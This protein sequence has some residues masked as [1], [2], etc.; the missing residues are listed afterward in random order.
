[1]EQS[2]NRM[3]KC[4]I[5]YCSDD[6]EFLNELVG[7]LNTVFDPSV[8]K[9]FY[10]SGNTETTHV[11]ESRSPALRK[12]LGDSD[13]MI[14]VLTDNYMR[15]IISIA[16]L[17]TFWYLD[18]PLIPI[19][20]DQIG[21]GFLKTLLGKD[22]I[23]LDLSK[24]AAEDISRS[25]TTIIHTLTTNGFRLLD[26]NRAIQNL[27]VLF[28]EAKQASP[29]RP[30]IGSGEKYSN[31]YQYCEKNGIMK[32]D[33][34]SML[35][36]T[37]VEHISD[38]KELFIVATTGS[39]LINAL[40]SEFLPAALSRGMT[41]TVL[42]PN[43]SSSFVS[44]VAE[45]EWPDNSHDHKDRFVR[46]FDS[47]IYN[48]KNCLARAKSLDPEHCGDIWLGC[49]YTLMR[50]TITLAVWDD[51]LWGR[52]SMTIPPMRTVDGTPSLIFSSPRDGT[53][54]GCLVYKHVLRVKEFADYKNTLF[55]LSE[56]ADI[57]EFSLENEGAEE[58]WR[59]LYETAKKNTGAQEGDAE[60]IEVAAQHPLRKDGK[61]GNEFA[62]R[63]DYAVHL[64]QHIKSKGGE[65]RIYVPGSV[66]CYKGKPD[67]CSLSAAGKAYL[68][69]KD[70]PENDILGAE[71]NQHY[72]GEMGV[73]NTADECYV[74]AQIFFDGDYR[75]LHCVCSPN[76][77]L[78]KKLFYIA[79]GIIPF[80]YTVNTE[81]LVHDD[82]YE[83]FH[84][85]PEIIATDHTWQSP[86]SRQGKRTR[87]E[88]NPA[89][90]KK[91]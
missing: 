41:L 69:E 77:L 5:S 72:K 78:R 10:T 81:N 85:I 38:C 7:I 84:A 50:Q 4:F 2:S 12:A 31:I 42:I 39:N 33:N 55:R 66:H 44:D 68:M 1:M 29:G 36:S 40:A 16:E 52:L 47:V 60:L 61:P 19:V 45:L 11:G 34:S 20:F 91:D 24:K 28:S 32:L 18:K 13:L 9:F 25:V 64:Y 62:K 63:L 17:S 79:F 89:L 56:H 82:I 90:Q 37:L 80:F 54:F 58:Y 59:G 67:L 43:R 53:Q 86:E 6:K 3:R 35:L 57:H 75:R 48:L 87:M 27:S 88:R 30:Y 83:L 51:R 46:E 22:V 26:Q 65:V 73:Y 14:A 76:Q 70:I 8:C 49:S 71:E 23:Y 15:S 74:A 21:I